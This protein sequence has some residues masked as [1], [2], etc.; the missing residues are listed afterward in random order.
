MARTTRALV[1]AV[2]VIAAAVAAVQ[3]VGAS[4]SVLTCGPN[5]AGYVVY[6]SGVTCPTAKKLVTTIGRLR[7]RKPKVTIASFRGYV[8][9]VTHNRRTKKMKA[10]SC[11][12]KGTQATGFGWTKGGATVPL[13]PGVKRP[14]TDGGA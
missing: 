7:Y 2:M 1:V 9:L 5:K 11:L 10:G 12:R 14:S 3:P 6:A 13:P 4:S 8:C